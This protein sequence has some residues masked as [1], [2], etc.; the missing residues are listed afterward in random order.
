MKL[1]P[2]SFTILAAGLITALGAPLFAAT[3]ATTDP[4]GFITTS[5][6]GG[7]MASPKLSLVSPTLT[8]PVDWQG[9]ITTIS[10]NS[11]GPSTITVSGTPWTANQ[12]NPTPG[13]YYVEVVSATNPGALSDI[14]ATTTNSITASDNLK[15]FGV[16][17][18]TIRIRK[19]VT[20]SDFLGASNSAGLLASDSAS[21]ADEVLVY[22]GSTP[23]TYWYYDGSLGGTAGW[24]DLLFNPA[25]NAVIGPNEGVVIKRKTAGNLSITSA[26]SVKTGNS[27]IPIQ[28]GLN[29]LPTLSAEGL[30]LGTS[31]L[32]SGSNLLKASDAASTADEV[33]IYTPTTQTTYWYYDGSQGGT[34][35]WYDLL[36][37]PAGSVS[38]APGTSFVV[39]RKGGPAINWPL[40]APTSF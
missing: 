33:T 28:P 17:G 2:E 9:V 4:V 26:G 19:H 6:T 1:S 31:G 36:F 8:R 32:I 37:N 10:A 11:T 22:S 29:V 24:Y 30:T 27:L 12:F 25:G 16:A 40:P 34:A 23:S 18:D 14:S 5:A 39:N 20:L 13:S 3:E 7:T 15:S 35:G 38:I 21:T